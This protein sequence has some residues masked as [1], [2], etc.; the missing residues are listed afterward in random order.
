MTLQGLD[1]GQKEHDLTSSNLRLIPRS[2]IQLTLPHRRSLL[3]SPISLGRGLALDASPLL[4]PIRIETTP[5]LMIFRYLE[6]ADI[7][8]ANNFDPYLLPCSNPNGSFE[9]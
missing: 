2:H 1:L 7:L 5:D 8:S 4:I 6:P 9:V 3:D